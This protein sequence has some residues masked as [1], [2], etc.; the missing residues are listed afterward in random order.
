LSRKR[1]QSD[2]PGGETLGASSTQ[3]LSG[4]ASKQKR[5]ELKMGVT[6]KKNRGKNK[7]GYGY[8]KIDRT[9]QKVVHQPEDSSENESNLH[10]SGKK[11]SE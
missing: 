10:N 6:K 1:K 3:F 4:A 8:S 2:E 9:K 11:N 5:G 7:K